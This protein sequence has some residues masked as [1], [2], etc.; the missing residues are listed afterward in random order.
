MTIGTS[1]VVNDAHMAILFA[2]IAGADHVRAYMSLLPKSRSSV[3]LATLT[4]G[5]IEAFAKAAYLLAPK[6]SQ[7]FIGR[8]CD[9]TA[10][11]LYH[12]MK[13]SRFQDHTGAEIDQAV[14]ISDPAAG[15][16]SDIA[17]C[18]S[19]GGKGDRMGALAAGIRAR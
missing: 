13:Y 14:G 5:S 17:T 15:N 10:R 19:S 6:G 12:P 7:D 11:E 8:Y 1:T 3:A 18:S 16:Q 4:R 9:V 2:T